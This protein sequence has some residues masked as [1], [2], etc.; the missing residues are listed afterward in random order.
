LVDLDAER[1]RKVQPFKGS[2]QRENHF[3][4]TDEDSID[5]YHVAALID[6]PQPV[7]AFDVFGH[8]CTAK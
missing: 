4:L 5:E 8:S 3:E 6:D 2:L 1:V 7:S